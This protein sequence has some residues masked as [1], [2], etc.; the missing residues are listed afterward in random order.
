M[1]HRKGL[2]ALKNYMKDQIL[3]MGGD[4]VLLAGDFWQTLQVVP[5][6]SRSN[7]VEA[8]IKST[9]LWPQITKLSLD[10]NIRVYL[11]SDSTDE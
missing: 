8:C 1:A 2:H 4:T 11:I 7:E 6:G 5:I 10:K 9:Y 3:L